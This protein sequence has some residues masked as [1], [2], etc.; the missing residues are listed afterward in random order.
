[1]KFL[2]K[3][4]KFLLS[5]LSIF[6]MLL[7]PVALTAY[8]LQTSNS[9]VRNFIWKASVIWLTFFIYA[10]RIAISARA[11]GSI[12]PAIDYIKKL[13][14]PYYEYCLILRP[15]GSDGCIPIRQKRSKKG[16]LVN[17]FFPYMIWHFSKTVEQI[18]Q[19]TAKKILDCD[20]VALVDPKLKIVPDAPAYISAED[21]E[22]QEVINILLKR[23]L[24]VALVLPSDQ[25]IGKNILWEIDR[26]T[27]LGLTGRLVIVLPPPHASGY[28][29]SHS[30]L[31]E[32]ATAFPSLTELRKYPLNEQASRP[33]IVFPDTYTSLQWWYPQKKLFGRKVDEAGYVGGLT[34]TL[35]QVKKHIGNASFAEKYPYWKA[36]AQSITQARFKLIN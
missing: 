7:S 14:D 27:A 6:I 26:V 35:I 8:A 20:A 19:E 18:I 34:D 25:K 15:F 13:Q 33:I 11:K 28:R 22:W 2:F 1:M 31:M 16:R 30:M 10:T 32:L 5:P 21:E 29:K 17:I 9:S 23:A 24:I 36:S 4:F 3:R 12:Q